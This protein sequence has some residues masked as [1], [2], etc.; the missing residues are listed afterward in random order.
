MK[1]FIKNL[2]NRARKLRKTIVLPEGTSEKILRAADII[3]RKKIA[4]LILLG[5][6]NQIQKKVQELKLKIDLEQIKIIDPKKSKKLQEKYAQE[7]FKLRKEKGMTLEK[8][9]EI[10]PNFNYFGT[11]MVHFGD[12]DGMVTGATC[13]TADSIRPALQIIKTKKQFHKISGVYILILKDRILLCADTAIII[14]PHPHDLANIAIDTAETAARLGLTPRVAL[15]SFSTKGSADHPNIEK[16]H[17]ALAIIK[18]QKPDLIIDG[19]IQ[20]DAALVPIV[21]KSKAPKSPIQGNANVLIFPNLESGNIAYKLIERLANAIAIGPVLQGLNKPIND[22]SRGCSYQDI[23][24][25]SSFH[26]L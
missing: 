25:C 1:D 8:A 18:S 23:V 16:I 14:E 15:L 6:K 22:L 12:A 13:S 3:Q 17:E 24:I 2:H 10:I 5:P 7:L 26:R 11:M 9:H 4:G 21:A 20:A 19:E